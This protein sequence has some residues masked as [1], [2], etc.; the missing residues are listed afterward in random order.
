[1]N[2][3]FWRTGNLPCGTARRPSATAHRTIC[4]VFISVRSS[5]NS[6][7]SGQVHVPKPTMQNLAVG[8]NEDLHA[9]QMRYVMFHNR[10]VRDISK[11]EEDL[12]PLILARDSRVFRVFRD[13]WQFQGE[14]GSG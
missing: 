8:R 12:E 5:S 4:H 7:S 10:F 9:C 6:Y 11:A 13:A 14:R 2:C 3:Q 1:M